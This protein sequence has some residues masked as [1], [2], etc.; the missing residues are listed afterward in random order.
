MGVVKTINNKQYQQDEKGDWYE[1]PMPEQNPSIKVIDGRTYQK[2]RSGNWYDMGESVK[3]KEAIGVVAKTGGQAG[4]G[5][6]PS[7]AQSFSQ[8]IN[9]VIKTKI[10]QQVEQDKKKVLDY[11]YGIKSPEQKQLAV[12]TPE[13]S[14]Q[15]AYKTGHQRLEEILSEDKLDPVSFAQKSAA[16]KKDGN[17]AVKDYLAVKTL[18]D[19]TDGYDAANI[20][21][22]T[23]IGQADDSNQTATLLRKKA[24]DYYR[25]TSPFNDIPKDAVLS[26]KDRIYAAAVKSYAQKN[27]QFEAELGASGI[28]PNDFESVR[29]KI[30][31]GKMGFIMND[32]LNDKNLQTYLDKENPALK[33]AMIGVADEVLSDN[34]EYGI[35]VV[36]NEISRE[37]QKL[38]FN[39][40]IVEFDDKNFRKETDLVAET[41]YKDNPKKLKIYND[42]IKQD[43]DK[44]IDTPSFFESFA[45]GAEG[46]YKG[47]GN[48][49]SEPFRSVPESI[50]RSWDKEASN[51]SADPKGFTNALS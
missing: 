46:V 15:K 20:L 37:R 51:V 5:V 18:D 44:Y 1:V 48:T 6:F 29:A 22:T 11:L 16:G 13:V 24:A 41:L 49:F 2:D 33:D 25:S 27:P 34:H 43:P 4:G 26:L 7:E 28:D 32:V 47:I 10:Q 36:A 39:N 14:R 35:N 31:S 17:E 19:L 50:K 45:H 3:K 23:P 40:P 42:F 8:T 30:G 12:E 38:G 9:P 21:K